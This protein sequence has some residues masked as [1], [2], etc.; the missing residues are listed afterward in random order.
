MIAA[1]APPRVRDRLRAA[2][3]GPVE[4]VH[5]GADAVYVDVEGWCVGVVGPRAALV[6]C[7][8]RVRDTRPV[9]RNLAPGADSAYLGDGLLH[10]GG[11]PLP[12]GRLVGAY[13]PPLGR[14]V[15]RQTDPVTVEATP[16]A[17]VAGFV[18][19]H[20]TCGRI[21]AAA[22]DRLLGRGEG[23]T[24]LGDDVLSGWLA[25]HRA[26]GV[27]TPQVDEVVTAA[28]TRTTL[29]SAT[30]LDCAGHGE[31]VPQFAG[32][33]RALGGR[34]EPAAVRALQ[35]LGDTSGAGLHV[36]GRI[37]LDQLRDA[38]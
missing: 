11:V 8:L 9:T 26:A 30:L 38:A 23:L 10:I 27:P 15:A 32:W 31:V 35:A 21:D 24:P 28:R 7:A 25:M 19:S 2:A 13:V 18:A 1:S 6:P 33:V 22:A 36:G 12:I 4:I 34:A 37:A 16:P 14:E 29:L 3:D 17:T 5:A 20:V